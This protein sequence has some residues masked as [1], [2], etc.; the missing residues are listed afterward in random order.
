MTAVTATELQSKTAS[1]IEQAL[2]NPVQV[3]RNNRSVVVLIS[4][5]EYERLKTLED[6]Y[7]GDMA[8][9]AVNMESAGKEDIDNLFKRLGNV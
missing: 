8:N 7:W 2:V 5:K 4:N 1:I 6:A 9:M 3:T